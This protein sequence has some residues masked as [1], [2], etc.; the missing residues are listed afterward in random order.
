[1][2]L[3]YKKAKDEMKKKAQN[4][5]ANAI[6]GFKVDFDE[7]SARAKA[8]FM[9][10]ATGTA[11]IVETS[12]EQITHVSDVQ[13]V[14]STK[15]NSLIKK[16]ELVQRIENETIEFKDDDWALMSENVSK[17]IIEPLLE[18]VYPFKSY[19]EQI[20]SLVSLMDYE[21][22]CAIVY[23]LYQTS[24]KNEKESLSGL[25][26]VDIN[27]KYAKLI[28]RCKLFHPVYIQ[29]LI[30]NDIIKAV[31]VLDCDK[32][33]YT[34]DDLIILR[35]ICNF[36]DNL[37]NAG[38]Y[39]LTKGGLFSKGK[40]VFICSNGHQND[41]PVEFCFICGQNIKGLTKAQMTTIRKFKKKVDLLGCLLSN[42]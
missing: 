8:M 9:L 22:A 2:N 15:L 6:L 28:K 5:G 3:M 35:S 25:Q 19:D 10:S 7:I 30:S 23:R 13:F 4:L 18:K 29:E 31:S 17:E 33:F 20:E 16:E 21:E 42:K 1:M 11:C 37:P 36:L 39:D 38:H 26:V 14:E 40:E 41:C 27:A 24:N 12:E 34:H 32:P